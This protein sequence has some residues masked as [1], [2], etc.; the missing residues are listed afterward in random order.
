MLEILHPLREITIL[1]VFIRLFLAT[2]CGG[3]IGLEREINRS[4]AGLRTHILICLG[5]CMTTITS[6]YMFYY[7]G[8]FTDV[9][10]LGAQVVAGVGFIGTGTIV[11]TKKH[12]IRGLTTAA[13]IWTASIIGLVLGAGFYEGGILA[14]LT[15]LFVRFYA[16]RVSAHVSDRQ[17][18]YIF[19]VEYKNSRALEHII[20]VIRSY[21]IDIKSLETAKTK[22]SDSNNTESC[23]LIS[24][25]FKNK[26][27]VTPEKL[28][29][30]LL[31]NEDV[32]F[33]KEVN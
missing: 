21:G 22:R 23:A 31:T 17:S 10:R 26:S 20:S 19:Y 27:S 25:H 4:P 18:E 15:V 9:T 29:V 24:L 28:N 32:V 7:L 14:T 1:T 13:G 5:A 11:V 2:L 33:V 30:A 6:Q 3:L 8:L 12:Q 16:P